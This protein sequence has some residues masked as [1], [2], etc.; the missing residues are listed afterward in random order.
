MPSLFTFSSTGAMTNTLRN[1][2]SPASTWLGGTDCK[3]S[4]L[5]VSDSTTKILVK[6]VTI[7]SND[8]ATASTVTSSSTEIDWLGLPPGRFTVTDPLLLVGASPAGAVGAVGAVGATGAVGPLC[9]GAAVDVV[10]VVV[11]CGAAEAAVARPTPPTSTPKRTASRIADRR[12]HRVIAPS[13]LPGRQLAQRVDRL[14]PGL[15]RQRRAG[16]RSRLGRRVL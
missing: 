9:V 2:D 7:S 4:A 11:G 12:I 10:V 16:Q 8:G 15:R 6:L 14:P 3:P 13:R 1:S 5:R